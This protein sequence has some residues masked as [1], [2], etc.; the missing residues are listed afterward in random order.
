[1]L[2]NQK[3]L[4]IGMCLDKKLK[5]TIIN[6]GGKILSAGVSQDNILE[7]IEKN[8]HI[9]FDS[10]NSYSL[11][12]YPKY[13]EFKINTYYWSR[14]GIS[15]DV[16]AG[17][18]NIKYI[19]HYF[20]TKSLIKEAK[21]YLLYLNKNEYL[22]IFVYSMHYPFL[23]TAVFLK[24]KLRNVKIILIVP[25]LPQYMDLSM[26]FIKKQLKKVDW[27]NIKKLLPFI[28]F[29]IL[30]SSHMADF[31]GLKKSQWLLMEGS[32]NINDIKGYEIKQTN[33][34][35]KIIIMYSGVLSLKYGIAELLDAFEMIDNTYYELWLTGGGD[36]EEL[37]EKKS[38]EDNRIKYF[39]YLSSRQDLLALQRKASMLIN[40]RKPDEASKY[41]FPSKLF[42]YMLS[43]K[44]VLSTVIGGI[45]EEYFNY[46][47]RI[48]YLKAENIKEA[49]LKVAKMPEEKRNE[50]GEKAK[51]F[52]VENKNN[53]VQGKKIVEYCFKR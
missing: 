29:Y 3:Y 17:Y 46:I 45:P 9:N 36:A 23:K 5:D 30:Y 51:R 21:K 40:I 12:S 41:C 27:I 11:S 50:I 44:P 32:V 31:L 18:I 42:E 22:N 25:D 47:I 24:K 43:G 14:N 19:N 28:D 10:I 13:K 26:S 7:G 20:K 49:I 8:T 53:I 39:G 15:K 16:F 2:N 1:M 4:W 35:K 6:N 37:I 33:N 48:E 52:I 38:I 34:D